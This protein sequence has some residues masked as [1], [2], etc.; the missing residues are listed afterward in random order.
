[1]GL[2]AG[3]MT[4]IRNCVVERGA[5]IGYT[6]TENQ[7]GS[8]A[9][10]LQ[11]TIEN[12]VSYATVRGANYV[13]GLVGAKDNAMGTCEVT[14]SDFHGSVEGD[15][16]VGGVAGGPYWGA[17]APN[18]YRLTIAGC[19]VD[20]TVSGKKYVGGIIGGD[21]KVAQAWN[22][23][24]IIGNT[25]SGTATGDEY[26]GGIIG[27]YESLN[28]FDNIQSNTYSAG[29]DVKSG[30]GFV[31][32]VD[33]NYKNPTHPS[34]TIVFNTETDVS[35]APA[36]NGCIWQKNHNR[37]DDPLGKDADKLARAIGGDAEAVCYK[38]VASGQY[39]TQYAVGEDLDLNGIKLTAY[40]T[41]GKTSQ[42]DLSDVEIS[43]YDKN[44]SGKQTVFLTYK[45]AACEISIV[46][47]PK[48]TKIT[49]SV[50]IYGDSKHGASGGVHGLAM[51]GLSL[52]ASEPNMEADTTETVWDVLKRVFSKHS[53]SVDASDNNQYNTIYIASINGLGEFDNGKLSG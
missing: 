41:D 45:T 1:M 21:T 52:W 30:I 25:F 22:S 39:K 47:I 3:F 38:L 50:S 29:G 28:K 35:G 7:I 20:G 11:G 27:Y 24:S 16:Y 19:K 13:G 9:G 44:E 18:A 33:T 17:A 37:T 5:V 12:C 23:Y 31:H 49:V 46:V 14:N 51:G 8:F 15:S 4:T 6:G 53:M 2:L 48:S 26:V 42:V 40:W 43:G 34:G 36:V 10:K 32:Y